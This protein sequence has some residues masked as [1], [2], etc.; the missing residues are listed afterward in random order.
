MNKFIIIGGGIVGLSVG[1]TLLEKYPNAKITLLEKESE[2]ASHQTGNNSGVIHSGIYYTPGSY[3]AEFAKAGS[4]SMREFCL[5]NDVKHDI[6]GKV[7]VATSEAELPNLQAVNGGSLD[8]GLPVTLLEE[9]DLNDKEPHVTA[10]K[11][12]YDPTAGIVDYKDV[13][14]KLGELIVQQGGEIYLN[15]EVKTIHEHDDGVVVET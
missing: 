4:K 3:K 1:K 14:I 13:T 11:G 9:A 2:L 6:C 8:N 15:Q 10:I 5:E 7:I 12:I